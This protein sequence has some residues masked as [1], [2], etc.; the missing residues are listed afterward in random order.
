VRGGLARVLVLALVLAL[1]CALVCAFAAPAT[2]GEPRDERP[3]A[4]GV[5]A[6]RQ[7]R[8]LALFQDGNA[9]F[10]ESQHAQA[11]AL[12][13]E[14][15]AS[16]DHP[17][18]HFNLAVALVHLDRPLEAYDQLT[19]ALA[20]GAAPFDAERYAQ[21]LG[22]QKLLAARLATLEVAC[23]EPDADVRLDGEPLF[24]GPGRA[25]RVLEPGAHELVATRPGYVTSSRALVLAAGARTLETL[26]LTS[27]R[28]LARSERRWAVW[29]PW[30]TVV[31][32]A[33]VVVVAIPFELQ[34]RADLDAFDGAVR[35]GCDSGCRPERLPASVRE[36]PSSAALEHGVAIGLFS[37]GAALVATGVALAIANQPRVVVRKL[38]LVPLVG[39][40]VAGL[41]VGGSF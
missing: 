32:G 10:A 19:R 4:A 5:S 20:Y 35:N 29:K 8:A 18:I 36:L 33:L 31:S 7:A 15:L 37:V 17:S 9:R 27:L 25:T 21:A 39:G 28:A 6:E 22:Y 24:R 13:R 1:V 2:A 11:A 30:L 14:A 38:A 16:W 12:F 3:W 23:A 41:A 34:A 40:G 26:A